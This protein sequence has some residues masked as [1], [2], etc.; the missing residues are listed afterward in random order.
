MLTWR[1]VT[2]VTDEPRT[3]EELMTALEEVTGRLAAGDLGIEAAVDLY[4]EAQRL[5]ALASE[6]LAQVQ[7]RVEALA[8][9]ERPAPDTG[10]P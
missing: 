2:G 9:S 5:H 1:T 10:S 6:R 8:S 3:F 4:E 7:A